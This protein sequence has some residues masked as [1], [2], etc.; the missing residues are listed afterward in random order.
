MDNIKAKYISLTGN[1]REAKPVKSQQE[2][3][4]ELAEA[5]RYLQAI[6]KTM[7]EFKPNHTSLNKC[8]GQHGGSSGGTMNYS[9]SNT[10]SISQ[11][12]TQGLNLTDYYL[13]QSK[14]ALT[15]FKVHSLLEQSTAAL[16][17]RVDRKYLLPLS[18]LPEFFSH[19]SGDYTVLTENKEQLFQY[20]TYYYDSYQ[21]D[22]YLQHQNGSLNRHKV[23]TR[24]YVS[25]KQTFLELKQKTNQYRT[26]KKRYLLTDKYKNRPINDLLSP[27]T[28]SLFPT[29][30]RKLLVKYNRV[31][32]KHK[33]LPERITFDINLSYESL[34]KDI[35][36][37]VQVPEAVIIE[38]KQDKQ[39]RKSKVNELLKIFNLREVNFSKYCMGRVLCNMP[40]DL[41]ELPNNIKY[42]RFKTCVLN[43]KSIK[44]HF[45]NQTGA[46]I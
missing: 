40:P 1:R 46:L 34:G 18:L 5:G 3:S 8:H 20:N 32:L 35:T 10:Q 33:T 2:I 44:H 29:L 28:D 39:N 16:M 4:D 37:H 25:S 21:D 27:L 42:N 7:A 17:N 31:T 15:E 11:V 19:L 24:E 30:Y 13:T 6:K 14:Q 9:V 23:R 22:F 45:Y 12:K 38:I 43:L 41:E 26:E 36:K